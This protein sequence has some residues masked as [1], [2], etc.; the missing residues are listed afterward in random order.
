MSDRLPLEGL[1]ALIV[2]DEYFIAANLKRILKINGAD[3]VRM[4][5]SIEDAIV[6]F[7]SEDFEFA[8][9]DIN[10]QG[11]MTFLIA[12][13]FRQKEVPFAF[14]S[15]FGRASIPH[16]F[17]K[18]PNWGKLYNDQEIVTGIKALWNPLMSPRA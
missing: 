3:S 10:I 14:V 1:R 17:D 4:S 2:E 16:R 18:V 6:H 13:L 12:D 8:L 15:G 11:E 9:I 5:G 7:R